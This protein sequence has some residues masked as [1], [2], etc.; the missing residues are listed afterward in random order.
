MRDAVVRFG[1]HWQAS[2]GAQHIERARREHRPPGRR[3]IAEVEREHLMAST[4]RAW[5][6]AAYVLIDEVEAAIARHEHRNFLAVFDQLGAHALADS[7]VGLLRLDAAVSNKQA[8][9]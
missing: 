2:A 5:G 6:R 7:G 1:R 8:Y 4:V 3:H 9:G